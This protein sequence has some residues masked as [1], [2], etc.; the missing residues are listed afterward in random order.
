M[1]S[2]RPAEATSK[3]TNIRATQYCMYA[4][5][6]INFEKTFLIFILLPFIVTGKTHKKH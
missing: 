2:P 6:K 3:F 4:P 1:S 5:P